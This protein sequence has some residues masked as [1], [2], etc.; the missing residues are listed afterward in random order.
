L[1][2]SP[3]AHSTPSLDSTQ[4]QM[5]RVI[6]TQRKGRGSVFTSH[7]Q[8]R[9]GPAKLRV[10]DNAERN[11]YIKGVVSEIVHDSG[12]GAPLAK[13][14][15]QIWGYPCKRTHARNAALYARLLHLFPPTTYTHTHYTHACMQPQVTFRDPYKYR[16][17]KALFIAA[18][19]LYTGQVRE[20]A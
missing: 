9:V 8:H 6:R 12:R 17:Q 15:V 13:V 18:E 2:P 14:C 7:T 19:G 16:H 1:A 5:G 10:L 20:G 3:G 4:T 11:S